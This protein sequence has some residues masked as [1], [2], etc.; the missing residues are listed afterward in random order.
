VTRTIGSLG[1]C[2][3]LAVGGCAS[4]GADMATIRLG[5][6]PVPPGS[7]SVLPQAW[8]APAQAPPTIDGVLDDAVWLQAQK[9]PMQPVIGRG[10]V[11][12]PEDE[13]T[14]DITPRRCQQFKPKPGETFKWTNASGGEV[15]HAGKVAADKWGLVTLENVTVTKGRNRIVVAK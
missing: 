11:K 1:L 4:A 7:A 10:R 12:A 5:A 13:S 6:G 14:V 8:A 3:A 15:V 9:L 2:V